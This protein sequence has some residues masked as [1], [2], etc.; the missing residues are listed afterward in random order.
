MELYQTGLIGSLILSFSLPFLITFL[1]V[2]VVFRVARAKDITAHQNGR[3]CHKG[4]IPLMGGLA[5][6]MGF[7]IS[8][9]VLVD[10]EFFNNFRYLLAGSILILMVGMKDD[11][12]GIS[13]LKKLGGQLVAA[14]I[15]VF[16]GD[17]RFTSLHGFLGIKEISYLWSVLLTMVTIIGVTN[18]FNLI[19]GVDGLAAGL[20]STSLIALALWF[21]LTGQFNLML[22]CIILTGALLAFLPFNLRSNGRKMFMGDTGSLGLGFIMAYL[23][24]EFNQT[25]IGITYPYD[26]VSA[27]AVSIGNVFVPVFDTLRVFCLRIMKRKSP[28]CAD[29]IHTHHNLLELGLSHGQTSLLLVT[30]NAGFI[31]LSFYSHY[32]GTTTLLLV[33]LSLGTVIFFLPNLRIKGKKQEIGDRR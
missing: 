16:M 21:G 1:L 11:V 28:F 24:I 7:Y 12:M 29:K 15:L 20:G 8:S 17:I 32:L 13:A 22:L 4:N 2:P 9:L 31:I 25:N 27:P 23:L 5:I 3:T 26:L 19:D 30:L 10:I 14:S 33:L 6:F 18:C